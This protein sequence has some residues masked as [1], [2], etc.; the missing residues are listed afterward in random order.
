[1]HELPDIEVDQVAAGTVIGV[2]TMGP[3]AAAVAEAVQQ[4]LKEQAAEK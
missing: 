3:L 4:M 1:M 2:L